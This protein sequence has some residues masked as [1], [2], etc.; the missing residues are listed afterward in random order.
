MSVYIAFDGP[1]ASG[2]DTQADLLT[3]ALRR[4]GHDP[5]RLNEPDV[6]LPTGALLRSLIKD[7]IY[8]ES[9]A[10][11][12]LADRLAVQHHRIIPALKA[13][14]PVVSSRCFL[15]TLVYQQDQYDLDWLFEIHKA[16]PVKLDHLFI[17]DVDPK[18]AAERLNR[19]PTAPEYYERLDT[20]TRNR[21]RYLDLSRDPRMDQF[22]KPYGMDRFS[23]CGIGN[24]H[25]DVLAMLHLKTELFR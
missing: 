14:R 15:S 12:F 10:A 2:K 11:L 20:Q 4:H 3:E 1:D 8:P 25:E 5:L 7:G 22:V 6:T 21:Q 17:L 23:T 19:R 16:L 13:G 24:I 18:E 9:H